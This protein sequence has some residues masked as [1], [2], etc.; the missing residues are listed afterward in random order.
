MVVKNPDDDDIWSCDFACWVC[1]WTWS[2]KN[3]AVDARTAL[4]GNLLV[5][6]LHEKV[7]RK[8]SNV[9]LSL[10][11]HDIR[12]QYFACW[13]SSCARNCS[14]SSRLCVHTSQRSCVSA[15]LHLYDFTFLSLCI[16]ISAVFDFCVTLTPRLCL[17]GPAL[18]VFAS[19][20]ADVFDSLPLY[21]IMFGWASL[22]LRPYI[23]LLLC[24]FSRVC[25]FASE[26][27]RL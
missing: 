24:F 6:S 20:Y 11:S 12:E 22:H 2:L 19:L 21:V 5:M 17:Y 4:L 1:F 9:I 10:D 16:S 26:S 3:C 8:K 25:I 14:T 13:V 18:Y 7:Q 23:S 15:A 27:L